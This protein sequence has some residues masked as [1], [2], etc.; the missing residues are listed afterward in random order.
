MKPASRRFVVT[1]DRLDPMW[2]GNP[3]AA[4]IEGAVDSY[5]KDSATYGYLTVEQ[6]GTGRFRPYWLS[7][8]WIAE[9]AKIT[10]PEARLVLA[11][12]LIFLVAGFL[13]GLTIGYLAWA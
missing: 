12:W 7:S 4:D 9:E 8:G 2:R 13:L 3:E 1:V 11:F 10:G 6:V 5:M